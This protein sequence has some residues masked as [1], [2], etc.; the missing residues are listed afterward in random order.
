MLAYTHSKEPLGN[1]LSPAYFPE[2]E[3]NFALK[4]DIWRQKFDV[5][6]DRLKKGLM[7]GVRLD[8]FF[9]GF[10][11][12][13]HIPHTAALRQEGVKV[14]EQNSRGYNMLLILEDQ[15]RPSI[16]DVANELLGQEIWVAWPHMVEAKV[17]GVVSEA[18]TYEIKKGGRVT[19]FRNEESQVEE[20]YSQVRV[21]SEKYRNRWGVVIGK[22]TSIL[23]K[24]CLMTGRK[25][26]NFLKF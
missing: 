22:N 8:V 18:E 26:W 15:G 10:P 19:Q 23:L 24:A 9:P 2:I 5:P 12:L 3:R 4:E 17:V 14:F 7:E 13:K 25:V 21:I 6:I 11:T 1:Y 16:K 20:F